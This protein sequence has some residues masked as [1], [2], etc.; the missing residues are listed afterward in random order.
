VF[1]LNK[2]LE[3]IPVQLARKSIIYYL[4]NNKVMALPEKLPE[5]LIDNRAGVFVSLKKDERLRGCIGTF[6][7][8]QNNIALEIIENAVSAATGDP[9]FP[10][11]SLDEVYSLN[12]SVD[13][14]SKPEEV[15]D[16]SQLDPHK[17]GVIVSS[18]YKKGLLLPDL[19]GVDSI[20]YQIEIARQKAGIS[21][22]E[23]YQIQRFEVKRYY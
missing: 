14:L 13:I 9:R 4:E 12:I 19:E 16:I 5:D 3:S 20:K 11:V 6:L 8:T 15:D 10:S 21:L 2:K 1:I 23:N 22:S 18:G 7:P 17:Y